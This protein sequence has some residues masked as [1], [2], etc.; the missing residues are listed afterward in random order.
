[1]I[2]NTAFIKLAL[3]FPNVIAAPH[4]DRIAF[5]HKRIFCTLLESAR[6]ANFKLSPENQEVFCAMQP[7]SIFPVA[8]KWGLQGWTTILLE[9]ME[10]DIVKAC[11]GAAYEEL[12]AEGKKHK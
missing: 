12:L 10:E 4:F 2:T 5:K 9:D 8:N 6:S 11:M 3:S 7:E 1:M